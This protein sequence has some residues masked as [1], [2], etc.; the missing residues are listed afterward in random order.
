VRRLRPIR[1]SLVHF[2]ARRTGVA[3]R[4]ADRVRGEL[5]LILASEGLGHFCNLVR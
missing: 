3:A 5:Q 1:R 4:P 2:L